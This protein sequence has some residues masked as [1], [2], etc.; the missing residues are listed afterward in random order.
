MKRPQVK[1]VKQLIA[2]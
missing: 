1:Q 2:P